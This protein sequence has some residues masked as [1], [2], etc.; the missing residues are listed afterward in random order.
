[1][2]IF[3]DIF[4]NF[5]IFTPELLRDGRGGG[6]GGRGGRGGGRGGFDD[7][8]RGGG[9]EDRRGGGGGG[10]YNDERGKFIHV[11]WSVLRIRILDPH[12]TKMD[13]DSGH[14]FKIFFIFNRLKV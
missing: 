10:G 1:M 4:K 14:F 8:G 12:I 7:R 13:P 6:R 11:F 3:K 5:I 9:F 2:K